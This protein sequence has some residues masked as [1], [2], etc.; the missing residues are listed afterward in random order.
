MCIFWKVRKIMFGKT[1]PPYRATSTSISIIL[2]SF[3]STMM[4]LYLWH[5]GQQSKLKCN[6]RSLSMNIHCLFECYWAFSSIGTWAV[7]AKQSS[8]GFS[9][10]ILYSDS[11]EARRKTSNP[12]KAV[13]PALQIR[14][15]SRGGWRIS[16]WTFLLI[17]CNKIQI[18]L[19]K[20][21]SDFNASFLLICFYFLTILGAQFWK[22]LWEIHKMHSVFIQVLFFMNSWQ[23]CNSRG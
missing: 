17:C 4:P 16:T 12:P 14:A 2:M 21:L 19:Y 13:G 6:E 22:L 23:S 1:S 18:F 20:S 3:F 5:S 9:T 15:N 8:S 10:C 7:S 11:S